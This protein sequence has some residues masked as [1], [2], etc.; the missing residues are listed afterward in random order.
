MAY[1]TIKVDTIT[2]TNGGV[3]K[4]VSISG[5]VQNPTFSG[6][7]TSTGTISGATITGNAG[8][9]TTITGGVATITSGVFAVGSVTNPSISFSGDPNTGIYSPGADQVAISTGGSN[10][11]FIDSNGDI[12]IGA[13]GNI[14]AD[15]SN[16]T[17]ANRT[18]FQTSTAN[19]T[20]VIATIPNGTGTTS[21]FYAF[22]DSDPTNAA[23]G[24]VFA[25]GARVVINSGATGT[26]TLLPMVFNTNNQEQARFTTT[27]RYF[28]MAAGTGG[29]QF[30]GD[31]AA[32]NA[33]DDYEEGTY[34][35]QLFDAITGGNASATTATGHYTK[36][37]R[38]VTASI[39]ISNFST[40]GMTAAAALHF[41]LP[42][43]SAASA[44]NTGSVMTAFTTLG[45][46]GI[47]AYVAASVSRAS[48]Y[49]YVSG[50]AFAQLT[51]SD[52]TSG[53]ADIISSITYHAA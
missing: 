49:E 18:Y 39:S 37:G 8:A 27:D 12:N 5:L 43:T 29:I 9:F 11:L 52:F 10:R 41:S 50:A 23:Y 3:D 21:A 30:K 26:G 45:A 38:L 40:A 2:F 24:G 6:N 33:L 47:I 22:N 16:A 20:T 53:T 36:V 13:G 14:V 15:F 4:S 25:D 32:V 17:V 7:V 51:V 1:G 28:R 42:F 46:N 48:L 44:A 19:Q 35:V 31:T 34:T